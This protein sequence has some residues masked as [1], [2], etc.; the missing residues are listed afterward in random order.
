MQRAA[1]ALREAWLA[2]QR[3][4]LNAPQAGQVAR[5]TVQLGQRVAAGAPLMSVVALDRLWVEAN[6]KEVQLQRM[7]IGQ[8]VS[9]GG[10]PVWRQGR[11]QGR[12]AGLGA[13]TGSA[14]ALLPAQNA[15][16]NWIKVVQRVPVR[17]EL[18]AAQLAAHPLRVGLS[19][20]ATVNLA[21]QDGVPLARVEKAEAAPGTGLQAMPPDEPLLP[22]RWCATSSPA[23]WAS[24]PSDEHRVERHPRGGT[25]SSP[26]TCACTRA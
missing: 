26:H 4:E 16:G 12:V 6:F 2:L 23:T 3:T 11:V 14:F 8:P 20:Q 21:T 5:R 22:R 25:R 17:I 13:G 9:P 24:R 1:A 7:R 15:T 19:M 18:D 10:R